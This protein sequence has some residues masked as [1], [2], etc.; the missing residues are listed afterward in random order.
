MSD[1]YPCGCSGWQG[2]AICSGAPP[3]SGSCSWSSVS[4][5]FYKTGLI[6]RADEGLKLQ[7]HAT[8]SATKDSIT[9]YSYYSSGSD[10]AGVKVVRDSSSQVTAQ[11]VVDG[12]LVSGSDVAIT[13]YSDASG[14]DILV[15][16]RASGLQVCWNVGMQSDKEKPS[17]PLFRHSIIPN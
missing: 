2:C 10:N 16:M 7:L 5:D 17:H 4:T 12:A 9:A 11:S 13:G 3:T 14:I 15:A 6:S 1:H 8:L